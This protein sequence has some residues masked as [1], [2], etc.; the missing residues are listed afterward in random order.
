ELWEWRKIGAPER[1]VVIAK[2]KS[3][4]VGCVGVVPASV[5]VTGSQVNTSWQQDSI[6]APAMRRQG[7][8]KRLVS[9]GAEGWDLVL[10]KGTSEPM[11][12]LRKSLGFRDVPNSNYLVRESKRMG[13][14]R[15]HSL[16]RSFIPLSQNPQHIPIKPIGTFDQSFDSLAKK[17]SNEHV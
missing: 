12:A 5:M 14:D 2:E 7:L 6:V 13:D 16:L 8:G 11:Y 17:L 15:V 1:S 10:A 4:I 9:E 3:T